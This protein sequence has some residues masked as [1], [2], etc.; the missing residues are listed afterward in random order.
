MLWQKVWSFLNTKYAK[1]AKQRLFEAENSLKK[2]FVTNKLCLSGFIVEIIN[3]IIIIIII[4]V[5]V[6]IDAYKY[7]TQIRRPK[8]QKVENIGAWLGILKVITFIAVVLNVSFWSYR[9]K[10]QLKWLSCIVNILLWPRLSY[11]RWQVSLYSECTTRT[12]YLK[13]DH[14]QDLSTL[15]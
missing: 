9:N 7:T 10:K 5:K 1:N 3:L 14:W 15:H 12:S 6:R 8:A 11:V 13:T 2:S 4:I